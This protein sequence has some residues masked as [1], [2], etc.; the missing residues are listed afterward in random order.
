MNGMKVTAVI[1]TYKRKW[2]MIIRAIESVLNQTYPVCEL[3]LVDDNDPQSEF[4]RSIRTEA[5]RVE[6]V[7]YVPMG[8]NS[9]VSAARNKGIAEAKGDVIGFL[10]DD[11]EWCPDKIETQVKLFAEN[12]DAALVFSCGW[13]KE[14]DTG[15]EAYWW[16]WDIFKEKPTYADMLEWDYVGST[17][18]PLIRVDIAR[19]LGGFT[20]KQRAVE[21]YE[22]WTR[23]RREHPVVGIKKVLYIKHMDSAEHVSRNYART[24]QGFANIYRENKSEYPKY[25]KARLQMLWNISREG[26]KGKQAKVIPYVFQWAWFKFLSLF[27]KA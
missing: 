5:A 21:D 26:I 10:D 17:S 15:R 13:V 12:P 27:R 9:G 24:V 6:R 18:T 8:K 14:D 4:S 20:T 2:P 22:F 3:L 25:P 16:P 7:R 1:T 19:K 11:D 23:I